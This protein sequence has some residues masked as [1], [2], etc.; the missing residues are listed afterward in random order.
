MWLYIIHESLLIMGGDDR[1]ETE[2]FLYGALEERIPANH[3]LRPMRETTN[4]SLGSM[5][6]RF[7]EMC[8]KAGRAGRYLVAHCVIGHIEPNGPSG[9]DP[10]NQ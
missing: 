4:A 10:Y 1:Q 3:P 8:A 5:S 2:L 7:D 9:F 6:K